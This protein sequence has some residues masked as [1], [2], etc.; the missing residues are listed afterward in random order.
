MLGWIQ[1][2]LLKYAHNI[3]KQIQGLF[4]A[5]VD[6]KVMPINLIVR[7]YAYPKVN[8]LSAMDGHDRPLKN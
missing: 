7:Q 2:L 4:D 6:Q 3:S 1:K 5:W 8:S